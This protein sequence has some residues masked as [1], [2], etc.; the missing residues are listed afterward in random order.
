MQETND[1]GQPLQSDQYIVIASEAEVGSQLD[2][3]ETNS[4][5]ERLNQMLR[6]D[7]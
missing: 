2:R 7:V 6:N 3:T 5:T 1:F 4:T